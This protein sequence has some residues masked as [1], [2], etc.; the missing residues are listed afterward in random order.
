[1][2]NYVNAGHNPPI[3]VRPHKDSCEVFYLSAEGVPV[4]ILADS[5]YETAKFQMMI[6]DIFVAYTDGITEAASRSGEFWGVERL[7]GLLRCCRGMTSAEIVTRILEEVS[8]FASGESQR[9]DVT[10]VVMR[11]QEG[12]ELEA[13]TSDERTSCCE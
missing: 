9:D 13:E 8:D 5:Q 3:I 1:L 7:E 2:L 11:V 10:L 12:C 4:G 6:D